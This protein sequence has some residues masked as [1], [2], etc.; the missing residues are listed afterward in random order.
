MDGSESIVSMIYIR[1]NI[2]GVRT[3]SFING[4]SRKK[5]M[6]HILERKADF[7]SFK[8]GAYVSIKYHIGN[9]MDKEHYICDVLYYITETWWKYDD[10]IVT[11]YSGYPM[12]IYNE[13]SSDKKQKKV[14]D[15]IWMDQKVLSS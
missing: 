6:E 10:E 3:K 2:L 15:M 4:M 11:K 9:D 5:N 13:V 12:N 7:E 1:K 8:N 14:K